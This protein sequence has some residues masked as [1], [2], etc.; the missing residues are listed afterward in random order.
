MK[1][2]V[3]FVDDEP[4]ILDGLRRMLRVM[5]DQWEMAFVQSG[6]EALEVLGKNR[7]DVI[8]SDMRMPGM[9]GAELLLEVRKRHPEILRIILSGHSDQELVLKSVRPAHQYLAKPCDAETLINAV[10]RG[11]VL[12]DLLNQ[13]SLKGIISQIESLP[14][15]PAL[16]KEVMDELQS[17]DPSIKRIG[18]I[19]SKDVAMTAKILQLVNSAF[20]GLPRRI[21]N[22]ADACSLLGIETIEALVLSIQ[23]FS[24]LRGGD[25]FEKY[26]EKVYDH[27]MATGLIARALA[28]KEV[29]DKSVSDDAF[30]SG[31]LHD[32]GKIVFVSCFPEDYREVLQIVEKEKSPLR[33]VE[34]SIFGTMHAEVGA[35]LMGLWG[36]SDRIVEVLA[37]HHT[38]GH[39]PVLGFS[40][41]TAV[42]AANALE[43]ELAEGSSGKAAGL[44]DMEYLE[45]LKLSDRVSDW[46]SIC[47]RLFQE[48]GS[49][50][51]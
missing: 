49:D 36:M 45:R 50:G 17:G 16:Y 8:I 15:L 27:S 46:R 44:M 6:T 3:L 35:F 22:P 33:E 31:L 24:Q 42:H 37:F 41:L 5:R 4:K 38:P 40:P 11:G 23:I 39:C 51:R 48:E 30:M 2:R 14:T 13:D 21:S 19:I 34:K 28:Q 7:F 9:D 32:V 43:H 12:R 1:K 25:F 26:I 20:F 18:A 29:K 10:S 47:E